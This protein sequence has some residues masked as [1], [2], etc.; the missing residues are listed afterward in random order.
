MQGNPHPIVPHEA[1][2]ATRFKPGIVHPRA[3]GRISRLT[4][5]FICERLDKRADG[6]TPNDD[7]LDHLIEVARSYEV[8]VKGHSDKPMPLASAKDSVAAAELLWSYALGKPPKAPEEG[9]IDRADHLLKVEANRFKFALQ[10]LGDR[11]KA[12][13][14]AELT[15]FF[16]SLIVSKSGSSEIFL[17]MARGV[18]EPAQEQITDG[19]PDP[20]P[21]S[22]PTSAT[23]ESAPDESAP[24]P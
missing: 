4:V 16:N 8:I 9:D 6:R 5:K 21:D 1:G 17:R 13:S 20:V 24:K 2:K 22:D 12:M 14:E 3:G 19:Q 23:H 15:N 7:I 18:P 10:L 11:A